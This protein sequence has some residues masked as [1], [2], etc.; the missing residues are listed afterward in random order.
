MNLPI[1]RGLAG[2]GVLLACGQVVAGSFTT[3]DDAQNGFLQAMSRDGHIVAGSYVGGGLYAGAWMWRQ[4]AGYQD[5]PL[6]NA[7]GMNSWG[8]PIAGDVVDGGGFEVAA[9]Y[10]S[11]SGS[12]PTVVGPYPGSVPQDTFWSSSYGVSDNE[13]VVGLAQNTDGNAIAFRW[14][15]G[16]GMVRMPVDRP[17]T[18]SRANGISGDGG[19]IYGWNDR[20]DGYRTG[21][22]W[23]NGSPIY[24]TNPGQYGDA[25]GSPPGE[26]LGSNYDGSVVVGQGYYDDNL[27]SE[28]WR[29]TLAGGTQ[30]IGVIVRDGGGGGGPGFRIPQYTAPAGMFANARLPQPQPDGF[31]YPTQAFALAVSEDGN[32]IV[33]NS[34]IGNGGGIVDAFIWTPAMGMVFLSDYAAML[35]I[36]IPDSFTLYSANAISADGLTIAGQGIDPTGSFVVPWILD[37]HNAPPRETTVTAIG[38]INSN[39]LTDGPFVGFPVGA[40]VTMIFNVASAGTGVTPGYASDYKLRRAS[41]QL[42]ATYLDTIDYSRPVA[43]EKLDPGATPLLHLTNDNPRADGLVVDT[44]STATTGQTLQFSV[45]NTDGTLFDSDLVAGFNRSLRSDLFDTVTWAVNEPGHSM[46]IGL[47]WVTIQDDTDEMFADGFDN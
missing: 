6:L 9:A 8:Q 21:V 44:A 27:Y 47:Q 3:I 15:Q 20:E 36:S 38:V 35:G 22:I 1:I 40:A 2:A 13:I 4:G 39:D 25:F 7:Q 24:P 11:D 19:V 16:G 28:A 26:A 14:T 18:Y 41:F 23:V 30:P 42:S 31:F 12:T 32:T 29:W 17:D 46:T 5:L 45:S 33:G 34:G 10:Y 37:L 43:I